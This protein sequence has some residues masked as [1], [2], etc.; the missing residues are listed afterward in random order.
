MIAEW[1]EILRG[2]SGL[3]RMPG[4]LLW[5][6]LR[7]REIGRVTPSLLSRSKCKLGLNPRLWA[8]SPGPFLG[9]QSLGSGCL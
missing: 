8:P 2:T 5:G 1:G 3:G 7:L 6:K 9:V 4:I